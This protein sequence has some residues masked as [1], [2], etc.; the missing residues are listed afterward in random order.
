MHGTFHIVI[1]LSVITVTKCVSQYSD[2]ADEV[3]DKI[4][5]K[6]DF[7]TNSTYVYLLL[8]IMFD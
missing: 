7:V 2:I 6:A 5:S 4:K 3:K 1:L 8:L